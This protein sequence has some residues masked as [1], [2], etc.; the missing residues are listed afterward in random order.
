[1]KITTLIENSQ[2]DL[3]V[4]KNEHGLSMFIQTTNCNILFDTGKS[5]DFIDNAKKLNINISK[6]DIIVLSH[7][8]YDHCGGIK[9]FI[10]NFN[11]RPQ[12]FIGEDF[13]KNSDRY[14]YSD[15]KLK[16]DF[17]NE[18]G[19]TYVGIDF[20][21]SYLKSNRIPI[22]FVRTS[23]TEISEN[24]YICSNF[25][26]YHS[27]EKANESMQIKV[28]DKYI[29]DSFSDE[30]ALVLDTPKGLLILLGCSHPGVLNM[31][32]TISETFQ[33]KVLGVVGGTHLVE[34]DND[35]IKKS[36]EYF[37]DLD[38][39]MVGVSHCTGEKAVELFAEGC[40]GFFINKTGTVIEI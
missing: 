30:I 39:S 28:G 31:V 18:T 12:L 38:I 34:A 37:N 4:L 19:Y 15:G 27:F 36:I 24:I 7:A 32:T 11:I 21:E 40:K 33:K 13:F 17:S 26:K 35:R 16:T 23:V 29:T 8:H 5:G 20:N 25:N 14:H 3:K 10:E 1:M 2:D 22:N 6:T 9:R